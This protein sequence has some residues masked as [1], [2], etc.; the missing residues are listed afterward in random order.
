M[1]VFLVVFDIKFAKKSPPVV[2]VGANVTFEWSYSLYQGKTAPN[3]IR[4]YVGDSL[5]PDTELARYAVLLKKL[6]PIRPTEPKI[7]SS[8]EWTGNV[9]ETKAAFKLINIS[10]A[11]HNKLFVLTLF[12]S[13]DA[14]TTSNPT[15]E[16]LYISGM[17]FNMAH[18]LAR[19][20]CSPVLVLMKHLL[21][22]NHHGVFSFSRYLSFKNMEIH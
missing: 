9:T 13:L 4:L 19:I 1:F 7:C 16:K 11:A 2:V 10:A 21:K 8:V 5:N 22:R 18:G 3:L 12:T 6:T 15:P 20:F 14:S 17:V